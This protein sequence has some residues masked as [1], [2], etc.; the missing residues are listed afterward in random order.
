[1]AV[2]HAPW[3][4]I[5]PA[6]G[7]VDAEDVV[8][9]YEAAMATSAPTIAKVRRRFR[10]DGIERKIVSVVYNGF[11]RSLWPGVRSIDINGVPKL[12]PEASLRA[13]NLKSKNWLIDAEIMVKS[14]YL[15]MR[16]LE[17]NVFGR[18]RSNG[19]SNVRASACWEFFT[20]LIFNRVTG[21]WKRDLTEV[22]DRVDAPP[23]VHA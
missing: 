4:G 1:M 22:A 3:I 12:I 13:M 5:I 6:D 19:L 10:M 17:H 15:G 9:L 11:F 8:R 23:R 14:Y 21:A 16:I 2:A 7:Q 20:S 18:M